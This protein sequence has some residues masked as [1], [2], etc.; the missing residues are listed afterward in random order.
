MPVKPVSEAD[1]RRQF[2]DALSDA[3]LVIK[4]EPMMDGK[5]HYTGVRETKGK[6]GFY[7]GHLD[8]SGIPAGTIINHKTGMRVDWRANVETRPVRLPKARRIVRRCGRRRRRGTLASAGQRR[9]Q[10]R[11]RRPSGAK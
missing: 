5:P 8:G 7:I 2:R 4:G 11:R 6:R 1:A 10:L 3:G 9:Q